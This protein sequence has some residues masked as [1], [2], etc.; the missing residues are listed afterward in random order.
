VFLPFLLLM[1][2]V[3]A[4]PAMA[5]IDVPIAHGLMAGTTAVAAAL[6]G[7]GTPPGE[8]AYL[9]RLI[10]PWAAVALV[11]A[12]WMVLQALP[13]PSFLSN[14]AHPIWSSAAGALNDSL[15]GSI[16]IDPGM[17]M[18]ALGR[19]LT[20]LGI[21]LVATV[22]TIERGRA[23]S[24]LLALTAVS[25]LAAALSVASNLGVLSL[26][27]A[28]AAALRAMSALGEVI[29]V[30]AVIHAFERRRAQRYRA[31]PSET[32]SVVAAGACLAACA[33]CGFVLYSAP[34]PILVA[35]ACGVAV[36]LLTAGA[37]R[38]GASPW[39]GVAMVIAVLVAVNVVVLGSGRS[40]GELAVRFAIAG[41]VAAST[42]MM[43][44]AS[45]TGSGAGTFSAVLP[46]YGSVE[47]IADHARPPTVAALAV[48]ELGQPMWVLIVS[49][50]MVL[51]ASMLHRA[52]LRGRDW[53]YPAASAGAA[54]LLM[55]ESFA[56][57]TLI[58]SS[59]MTVA[60]V[61]AGVGLAQSLSRT[62][63]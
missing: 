6:V 23:R 9:A 21:I 41:P 47:D 59:V 14:F 45:T 4:V 63:Q 30:A 36:V 11:L 2:L 52:M 48:I 13:L 34:A 12:L 28:T 15:P 58:N 17:T 62:V 33:L 55:I 49:A 19:Y 56:D 38:L 18:M 40:S 10:R 8:A 26:A 1:L 29:S 39:V 42:R 60:A 35:T 54:V 22:E 27:G 32:V 5:F 3:C 20:A 57:A 37:R 16:S 53:Q 7:I 43:A 46:I 44:D 25:A 61:T 24:I 51:A 31:A 50:A